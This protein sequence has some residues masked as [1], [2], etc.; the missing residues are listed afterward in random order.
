MGTALEPHCRILSTTLLETGTTGPLRTSIFLVHNS[1]PPPHKI[2]AI[3]PWINSVTVTWLWGELRC[4]STCQLIDLNCNHGKLCCNLS[5]RIPWSQ[6][7]P[8][9]K[10]YMT[11]QYRTPKLWIILSIT[12][13]TIPQRRTVLF[14]PNSLMTVD[15]QEHL[16]LNMINLS[17]ESTTSLDFHLKKI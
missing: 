10:L 9:E 11:I 13:K 6:F 14:R 8:K 1:R 7:F 2:P 17:S 16:S 12:T 3:N 4:P 15:E 5:F